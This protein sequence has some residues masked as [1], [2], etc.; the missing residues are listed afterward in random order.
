MK[1]T[2]RRCPPSP[3]V[4]PPLTTPGQHPGRQTP[5]QT[6]PHPPPLRAKPARQPPPPPT[7][8]TA[9]THT[10]P[11]DRTPRRAGTAPLHTSRSRSAAAHPGILATPP[12]WAPSNPLHLPRQ[13][14]A[15]LGRRPRRPHR[16]LRRTGHRPP[17]PPAPPPAS[18][19]LTQPA[20]SRVHH[21]RTAPAPNG[22]T[23]GLGGTTRHEVP[24]PPPHDRRHRHHRLHP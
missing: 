12:R 9:A 10:R 6:P 23:H 5:P 3:A 22:V 19:A 20:K 11:R 2:A 15:L 17:H 24:R 7:A 13:T 21:R 8:L 1:A 4:P 16:R 14:P 18:G